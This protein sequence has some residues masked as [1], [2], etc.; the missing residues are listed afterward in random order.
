MPRFA[1]LAPVLVCGTALALGLSGCT[2]DV[3]MT[4]AEDANDPACAEVIVR[5][6]GELDGLAKRTTNAQA[7]G[8]WGDPAAIQLVCG[9]TPGGPTTNPCMN[10]NGVDW[11]FDESQA[12][13]YRI[14]AYGRTPGL[15]LYVDTEQVDST[16]DALVEL[17]TAV[18]MLPQERE[19]TTY[20]DAPAE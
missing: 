14:E 18:K 20:I 1:T 9:E 12:P 3:P 11:V 10:V 19:C 13:I 7:T 15:A 5:L 16:T 17:T 2:P 4:A 8:A 6:P